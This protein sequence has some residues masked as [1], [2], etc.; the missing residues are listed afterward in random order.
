MTLEEVQKM[1]DDLNKKGAEIHIQ[2]QQA[3]GYK[4]ALLDLK[5]E[6]ESKNKENKPAE[7]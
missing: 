3:I 4:Q 2:L 6:E 1:I 5:Q 7:E